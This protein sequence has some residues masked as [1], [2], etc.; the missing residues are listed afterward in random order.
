MKLRASDKFALV[1]ITVGWLI[2]G[3]IITFVIYGL[4]YW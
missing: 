2:V 3:A 4:M 1:G